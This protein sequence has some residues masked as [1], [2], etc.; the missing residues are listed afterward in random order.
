MFAIALLNKPS[1]EVA[2]KWD[3][4]IVELADRVP[5]WD[6][7]RGF[8][9]CDGDR[10]LD[11][12][13][14]V[15]S[16]HFG[17][18]LRLDLLPEKKD[19]PLIVG[20]SGAT[21]YGKPDQ[22]Y[23]F[24]GDKPYM[25]YYGRNEALAIDVYQNVQKMAKPFLA[26]YSP[27]EV[28]WFGLEH[29]N[30][31]YNDYSRLPNAQDGVFAG[32]VYEEGKPG[33][34]FER[35]PPYVTTFNPG[36]DPSLPLYKPLPMFY[37]LKAALANEPCKWDHYAELKIPEPA[38]L[39]QSVYSEVFFI[40]NETGALAKHLRRIGIKF[41]TNKKSSVVIVDGEGLA[42]D[43][44][45]QLTAVM[46]SVKRY[47]RTI[48]VMMATKSIDSK[49]LSLLPA[50][51]K[52]TNRTAT[53]FNPNE[54]SEWGRYFTVPS[55]YFSEIE[56]KEP[57]L[58]HGLSGPFVDEGTIVLNAS[59]ID[60]SLFNRAPENK[61]CAQ[62]VLYE[63][64]QKPSGV[65]LVT[66]PIGKSTI[67]ISSINYLVSTKETDSFWKRLFSAMKIGLNEN[68]VQIEKNRG[69]QHDLLLDGP[70]DK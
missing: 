15:W 20:E 32:K 68:N 23:Q 11:G 37:A 6:P 48:L 69:V 39:P 10:D 62:V 34:Q 36:I 25:S 2:K 57:I 70:V 21:Y 5:A 3:D 63:K 4:K 43:Q 31:G 42:D 46:K 24:A 44:L 28:C 49:I 14:P 22:L 65:A 40:G 17:H 33:Y 8:I 45:K 9:T 35:I 12:R 51:I 61:K 19:K 27:S 53:A 58:K 18:G 60:W 41:S 26:Y 7:T 52:T 38:V 56:S 54:K 30:L 67:A 64:L 50:N 29:L 55:L 66:Y 13:L 1:Q 59:G 47:D 16:K